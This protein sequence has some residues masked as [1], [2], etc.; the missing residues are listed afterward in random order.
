MKSS[1][2]HVATH[3]RSLVA[4]ALSATVLVITLGVAVPSA[5]AL[6]TSNFCTA[7]FSYV[8]K[9]EKV[10]SETPTSVNSYHIWAKD[11]LPYYQTLEADAP[12]AATKSEPATS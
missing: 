8:E 2:A 10:F 11:L 9:G 7:L 1:L 3:T 6:G 12:N 4:A 5:H